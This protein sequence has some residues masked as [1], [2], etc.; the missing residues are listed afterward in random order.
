MSFHIGSQSGGVVNNV[1]HDQHIYEG[2]HGSFTTS[3]V[4][5]LCTELRRALEH[6]GLSAEVART[7]AREV[8]EIE[9]AACRTKPDRKR[10]STALEKLTSILVAAGPLAG[11]ATALAGPLG[12]LANWLGPLAQTAARMIPTL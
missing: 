10:A 7:A 8:D 2:Q 3:D 11:A 1:G 12:A 9:R 6:A 5:S 4:S